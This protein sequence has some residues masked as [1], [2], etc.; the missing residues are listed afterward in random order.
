MRI[1]V[2]CKYMYIAHVYR[3]S[4]RCFKLTL[5][6][7]MSGLSLARMNRVIVAHTGSRRN[8]KLIQK[9]GRISNT[10]LPAKMQKQCV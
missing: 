2:L 3:Y 4:P 1:L 10:Y 7:P 8:T 9:A 5:Y 6:P